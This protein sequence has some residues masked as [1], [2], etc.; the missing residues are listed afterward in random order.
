MK[1]ASD[2]NVI[3]YFF[4]RH[5]LIGQHTKQT[6]NANKKGNKQSI[7]ISPKK[8]VTMYAEIYEAIKA[9]WTC[10]NT[11]PMHYVLSSVEKW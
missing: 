11:A 7:Q 10:M 6:P 8:N 1:G 3:L 9:P 2:E 5:N 4:S